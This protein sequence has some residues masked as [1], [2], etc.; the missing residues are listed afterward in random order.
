MSISS[1]PSGGRR[2]AG[3]LRFAPQAL[4][5]AAIV[6]ASNILVEYPFRHLGLDELVTWGSF[7]YPF[8]FLV[9]DLTNRWHGPR[10]T[11]GVIG[12]GFALGLVLS[13]LAG[14]L[15]IAI[16]SGT[17]FLIGQMLDVTVFNW[18]R[19]QSWWRAPLAS[20][21]FGSAIDTLLF[22]SIAFVGTPVPWQTL[23]IGDFAVK[24]A[25]ALLS[26][27]PYASVMNLIK[28]YQ[29]AGTPA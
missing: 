5:M 29:A 14:D 15:R 9:S 10:V 22:F 28:P 27:L 18:L 6:L 2:P 13:A 1:I 21:T 19:R 26:L 11:R 16:A 7:T 25:V 17:A 24:I 20:S 12:V 23:A 3:V 4:A 8:A